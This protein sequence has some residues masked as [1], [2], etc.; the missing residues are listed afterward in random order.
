M[1][2]APWRSVWFAE[3]DLVVSHPDQDAQLSGHGPLLGNGQ[4]FE[5][6]VVVDGDSDIAEAR[7]FF[8]SHDAL[9]VNLCYAGLYNTCLQDTRS[10][11]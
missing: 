11:G 7:F 4:F 5:Q 1:D 3:N 10:R 9:H 2:Q 8:G 6:R